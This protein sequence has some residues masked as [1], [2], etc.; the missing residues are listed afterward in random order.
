MLIHKWESLKTDLLLF[1]GVYGWWRV[2]GGSFLG[3]HK[4]I[5]GLM[6][7][8]FKSTYTSGNEFRNKELWTNEKH[9]TYDYQRMGV[10]YFN[11]D[12]VDM[13]DTRLD[14]CDCFER[15]YTM[16]L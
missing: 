5:Q 1:G 9:Q 12:E 13:R 15:R 3:Y 4:L 11:V 16:A 14:V 2:I 10:Q 6:L 8:P 7:I